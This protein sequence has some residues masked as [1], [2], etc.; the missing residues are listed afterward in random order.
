MPTKKLNVS[1]ASKGRKKKTTQSTLKSI[2]RDESITLM[3]ALGR[4]L[5]P[6]CKYRDFSSAHTC[7][8]GLFQLMKTKCFC[9]VPRN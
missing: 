4:V 7:N 9:T 5:N 2:G 1:V 6:K 8:L 3:H